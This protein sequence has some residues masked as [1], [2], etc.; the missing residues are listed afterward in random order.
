MKKIILLIVAVLAVLWGALFV[1]DQQALIWE[2]SPEGGLEKCEAQIRGVN[3]K[4]AKEGKNARM[5]SM[6]SENDYDWSCTYFNGRRLI[7]E[8]Y[9]SSRTSCPNFRENR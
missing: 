4:W 6:C 3:K 2:V 8:R 1:S 5:L 9:S 7:T